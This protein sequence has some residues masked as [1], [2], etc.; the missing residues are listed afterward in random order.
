M[1]D[2]AKIKT[3]QH[4]LPPINRSKYGNRSGLEGPF[5][6][7][8][9]QVV[10]YDNKKGQY[11][12]P[13]RDIYLSYDDWKKLSEGVEFADEGKR[14]GNIS[15]A[16]L[17]LS[18]KPEFKKI[19]R[20]LVSLS[21]RAGENDKNA[22]TQLWN[23]L[24]KLS[25]KVD[26]KSGMQLYKMAKLAKTYEE[27]EEDAPANAT[28]TSVA[29]T[30]DDSSTVVVKKKKPLQDK[31][32]R[33]LK[34]KETIDRTIPDLEYPKDEITERKQQLLDLAKKHSDNHMDAEYGG[35]SE[36]PTFPVAKPNSKWM[37]LTIPN[38]KQPDKAGILTKIKKTAVDIDNK[39]QG[40]TPIY[41]TKGGLDIS[42]DALRKIDTPLGSH[43]DDKVGI[44]VSKKVNW[45][46]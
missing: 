28:G 12:N 5:M 22:P 20:N 37:D 32:M 11:L 29:G 35:Q 13:D 8:S 19:S 26:K 16:L 43:G 3:Q 42:V 24:A 21:M 38:K 10:Y 23:Q 6:T 14:L 25:H 30:G 39:L 34:I 1:P 2:I 4:K 40:K 9:G 15:Q 33:R 36:A 7:K 45:F 27:I 46:K 44:S 18:K 31:L 17:N 41:T